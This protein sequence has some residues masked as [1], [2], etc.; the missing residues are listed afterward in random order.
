MDLAR[1]CDNVL[2]MV[3]DSLAR[4]D[5]GG[6]QLQYELLDKFSSVEYSVTSGIDG[7]AMGD[8][9]STCCC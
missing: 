7:H 2:K 8:S 3:A 6:W 4:E 9:W 5:G 1:S